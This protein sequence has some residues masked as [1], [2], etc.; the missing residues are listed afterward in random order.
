MARKIIMLNNK[1]AMFV[2]ETYFNHVVEYV[3]HFTTYTDTYTKTILGSCSGRF[4]H[5]TVQ[6]SMLP[7][8][9]KN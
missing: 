8:F 6:F 7:P 4:R 9:V 1:A 5:F 2:C 3:Y